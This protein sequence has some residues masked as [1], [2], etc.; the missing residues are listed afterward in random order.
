MSLSEKVQAIEELFAGLHQEMSDFHGWSKLTCKTG[1]GTCCHKA[2][3]EATVLEL[4][5]FAAHIYLTN[6]TAAWLEKL[7]QSSSSVCV[8]FDAGSKGGG[9]CSQYKYRTLI[10]RLFGF[11]AR[12]NKYARKEFVTCQTIKGEQGTEYAITI[13]GVEQGGV[14]PVI[15][16]YYMRLASIDPGLARD[17][18]P[19]N[20]AIRRAIETVL[21]YYAYRD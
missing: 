8:F 19:V 7:E 15:N 20:E 9:F 3:I 17:F 12:T 10:C 4:L 16:N 11:S 6:Q 2:D 13:Q 18:Y 14:V 21:Q 1:C 5:P